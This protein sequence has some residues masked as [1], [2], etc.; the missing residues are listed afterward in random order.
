MLP[1]ISARRHPMSQRSCHKGGSTIGLQQSSTFRTRFVTV[2]GVG[3]F[4]RP[5]LFVR[6]EDEKSWLKFLEKALD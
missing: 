6:D 5:R 4:D 2:A 1:L 3:G